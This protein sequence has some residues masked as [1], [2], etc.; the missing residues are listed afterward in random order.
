MLLEVAAD[1]ASGLSQVEMRHL[2]GVLARIPEHDMATSV[3]DVSFFL[4]PVAAAPTPEILEVGKQS[5][6]RIMQAVT[7]DTSVAVILNALTFNIALDIETSIHPPS[8]EAP[9]EKAEHYQRLLVQTLLAQLVPASAH[10]LIFFWQLAPFREAASDEEQN[11]ENKERNHSSSRPQGWDAS[12]RHNL[13]KSAE[14][15]TSHPQ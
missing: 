2:D 3:R 1:P 12:L 5:I 8:Q 13:R 4:S 14:N 6:T 7:S 10:E 9:D 15:L 11:H